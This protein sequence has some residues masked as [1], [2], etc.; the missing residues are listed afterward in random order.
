MNRPSPA[1]GYRDHMPT[2]ASRFRGALL[3]LAT[4]DALGT[5]VEFQARGTFDPLTDMV[6]GG[7]FGLNPGEWTDDTSMAL[8]LARSLVLRGFDPNDQMQ[9]YLRW[10]KHGY[11]GSNGKCFDI[12]NTVGHALSK[13]AKT[14]DPFAGSADPMSAGNGSLMRLA[15]VP[16]Y[17]AGDAKAVDEHAASMSRT[18][19]GAAEAV[20]ACR[21]FA[22]QLA[23]ALGGATKHEILTPPPPPG[24]ALAPAIEAI[25]AGSYQAKGLSDIRGTGYV[26]RSLE[27]ALWCFHTARSFRE[28]VLAAANL[29]DDAD[30]TAAI[31]G[32]LAGAH[33]G[34][35]GI[36]SEWLAKLVMRRQIAGL[37]DALRRG[38]R[39]GPAPL[40]RSYWANPG[41]VLG[42]AYPG[43]LDTAQAT[44]NAKKLVDAGVSVFLNLMEAGE[45]NRSGKPFAAYADLIKGEAASS[46]ID[47]A[48]HRIPIRDVSVP[49]RPSM[50]QIQ[51]LL[52]HSLADDKSVYVH[53]WGGRGRTGTVIGVHLIQHGLADPDDFVDTIAWLRR[54]DTGGRESPETSEQIEFV[55]AF[56]DAKD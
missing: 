53:C 30:T 2:Q 26:V 20:D 50:E 23:R 54:A 38:R 1:N 42:G 4:G 49:D 5:T 13:F 24:R 45:K 29:G 25:R 43:H 51:S 55:R 8:C 52:D 12:G 10:S 35:E 46:G 32:Q 18:T 19:H 11:L 48:F 15:P 34:E 37:A 36:P 40:E 16:M 6:G 9:R 41:A 14:A 21:L 22:S 44:A 33:Y 47:I 56:T 3:G 17:F 31:C 27:A 7:K 39:A 28:A